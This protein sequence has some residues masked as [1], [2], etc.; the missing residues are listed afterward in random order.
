MPRKVRQFAVTMI[1]TSSLK[2]DT[3]ALIK[4]DV[5]G[6]LPERGLRGKNITV[7]EIHDKAR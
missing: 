6:A 7:K 5:K 4:K 1:V 2:E 3:E